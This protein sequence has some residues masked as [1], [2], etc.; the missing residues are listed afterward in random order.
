MSRI[1]ETEIHQWMTTG[2]TREEAL[3]EILFWRNVEYMLRF[4]R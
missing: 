3:E 4:Y 2:M 1:T